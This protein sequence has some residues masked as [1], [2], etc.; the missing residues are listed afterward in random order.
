MRERDKREVK[1][2]DV[3]SERGASGLSRWSRLADSVT[4]LAGGRRGTASPRRLLRPDDGLCCC[5]KSRLPQ[6]Q[7]EREGGKRWQRQR[8]TH[9][10]RKTVCVQTRA[11]QL[12]GSSSSSSSGRDESLQRI[13]MQRPSDWFEGVACVDED[14]SGGGG[15]GGR[16]RWLGSLVAATTARSPGPR[17]RSLPS[18]PRWR[19]PA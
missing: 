16:R 12:S 1:A 6:R 2:K 5:L 11:A 10:P 18:L 13:T 7:R 14:D 9:T 17:A 8:R 19:D 3:S 15:G 4:A